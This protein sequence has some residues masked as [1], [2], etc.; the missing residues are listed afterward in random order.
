MHKNKHETHNFKIDETYKPLNELFQNTEVVSLGFTCY[1]KMFI[2]HFQNSQTH[3]FDWIGSSS[4]SI[5]LLLQNDFKQLFK[6][7]DMMVYR[8]MITNSRYYLR[9]MHDFNNIN[10]AKAKKGN[11][12]IPRHIKQKYRRRAKRFKELISNVYHP[13]VFIYYEECDRRRP[14][15]LYDSIKHRF[16]PTLENYEQEQHKLERQNIITFSNLLTTKYQRTNY[17]II[18][19]TT[20]LQTQYEYDTTNKIVYLQIPTEINTIKGKDAHTIFRDTILKNITPLK[21]IT[22][23]TRS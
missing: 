5:L 17:L 20:Q 18:Y 3:F 15:T 8:N 23:I 19:F 22:Q 11:L 7:Y 13:T 9:F 4:W 16:P 14:A 10:V 21:K 12:N 6:P 2:K 1:P